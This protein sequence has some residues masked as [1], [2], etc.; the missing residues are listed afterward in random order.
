MGLYIKAIVTSNTEPT[1]CFEIGEE[2]KLRNVNLIGD[3]DGRI[4]A[5]YSGNDMQLVYKNQ[6][7]VIE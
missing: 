2:V 4:F 5:A 3:N 6:V 1:N 7:E